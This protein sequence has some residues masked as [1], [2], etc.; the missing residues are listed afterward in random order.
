MV[1]PCLKAAELIEKEGIPCGVVNMRFVKPIDTALLQQLLK[2]T[3]N[4]V[5]VEDHVLTGGFGSAVMEAMEG[6]EARIHRLG[7]PDRFIEHGPQT[8]L[9]DQ[10]GLSPEKIAQS[11]IQFIRGKAPQPQEAQSAR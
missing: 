7:I 5:T 11:T 9:R 6:T 10:V 8:V 3:P 4:F 1:H 2:Q